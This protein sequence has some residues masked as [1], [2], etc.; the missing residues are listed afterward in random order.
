MLTSLHHAVFWRSIL[1]SYCAAIIV[2]SVSVQCIFMSRSD[3]SP[4]RNAFFARADAVAPPVDTSLPSVETTRAPVADTAS[5]AAS[6]SSCSMSPCRSP[7]EP[8]VA[9]SGS[10]APAPPPAPPAPPPPAP[11]TPAVLV[12]TCRDAGTLCSASTRRLTSSSVVDS[13]TP[14]TRHVPARHR[15][16]MIMAATA[17][18]SE[19]VRGGVA[20]A[21]HPPAAHRAPS[22]DA[23]DTASQAHTVLCSSRGSALGRR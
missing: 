11:P 21:G 7:S 16:R 9:L 15:S 5:I 18:R 4:G 3:I 14:V 8:S 19:R 20:A 23:A 10:G 1:N 13:L 2:I 22:A 17:R 12:S 6:Y